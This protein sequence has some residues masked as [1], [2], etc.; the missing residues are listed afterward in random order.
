MGIQTLSSDEPKVRARSALQREA[1]R[2]NGSRSK[3]PKTPEGKARSSRNARRHGLTKRAMSDAGFQ[4]QIMHFAREIAGVNADP[5]EF[6]IAARIAAAQ[7]DLHRARHAALALMSTV[8]IHDFADN[9]AAVIR[10][11][12]I[13]RYEGRFFTRRNKAIRELDAC[14]L[15][16]IRRPSVL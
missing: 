6:A 12:A 5:A 10:L 16:E 8:G 15:A 9:L 14:L 3:G 4:Q 13:K 2:R 11:A 7:I 1:S